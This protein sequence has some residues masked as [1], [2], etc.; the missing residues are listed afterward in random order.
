L[1]LHP[2]FHLFHLYRPQIS[3]TPPIAER[4]FVSHSQRANAHI[5]Y[6]IWRLYTITLPFYESDNIFHCHY[7]PGFS[8]DCTSQDEGHITRR[9]IFYLSLPLNN[10]LLAP[11]PQPS[12]SFVEKDELQLQLLLE[13]ILRDED[14]ELTCW[15]KPRIQHTMI[16]ID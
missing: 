3:K 15:T 10:G 5:S 11:K 8:K 6:S 4:E 16:P 12:L 1:P 7:A 14:G 2:L 13:V 9:R